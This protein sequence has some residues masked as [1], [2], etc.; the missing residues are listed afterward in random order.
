MAGKGPSG[1]TL[2]TLAMPTVLPTSTEKCPKSPGKRKY[3]NLVEAETAAAYSAQQ[4]H[5][6]MRAYVCDGCGLYHVTGKIAYGDVT[7]TREDGTI[8]TAGMATRPAWKQNT[9]AP[10]PV[11]RA[12]MS[13]VIAMES[14]IMP[15]NPEARKKLLLE[16]LEDKDHVSSADIAERLGTSPTIVVKLMRETDWIGMRGAPPYGGWF[17]PGHPRLERLA[18]GRMATGKKAKATVKST[19]PK[20]G[21]TARRAHLRTLRTWLKDRDSVT[22]SEVMELL[23]CGNDLAKRLMK[24]AGWQPGWGVGAKWTPAD[25]STRTSPPADTIATPA[26]PAE[27][28]EET[29][30][31]PVD[32]HTRRHPAGNAPAPRED[33]AWRAVPDNEQLTHLTLEQMR[34]QLKA[35]GLEVRIQIRGASAG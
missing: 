30:Q 14:P 16:Y 19:V 13:E 27:Q 12:D 11:E 22:T 8:V 31:D 10:A 6:P 28:E 33:D 3:Y 2:P 23:G 17:K 4:Y 26:T 29:V 15:G 34:E 18:E 24:E 7:S 9:L 1:A 20:R 25:A 35:F 32:I 5:K 21:A